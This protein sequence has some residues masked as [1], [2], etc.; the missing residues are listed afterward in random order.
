MH[1]LCVFVPPCFV[2]ALPLGVVLHLVTLILGNPSDIRIMKEL[3]F[4]SL[5]QVVIIVVNFLRTN[6]RLEYL[7]FLNFA[8]HCENDPGSLD[9]FCIPH[10][11][12]QNSGCVKGIHLSLSLGLASS[13][14]NH[15]TSSPDEMSATV[16]LLN[17]RTVCMH[18]P[19]LL[20]HR[21]LSRQ[22]GT[23]DECGV[24][25][26]IWRATSLTLLI[27]SC[28]FAQYSQ[29]HCH[30]LLWIIFLTW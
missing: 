14:E 9:D 7:L 6:G 27:F 28:T 4:R 18:S 13:L 1:P 2:H 25:G 24:Q 19:S 16:G 26:G 5:R 17:C 15:C 20:H 3:V 21:Q 8:T 29:M 12:D 10:V 11:W 23:H 22:H 30:N